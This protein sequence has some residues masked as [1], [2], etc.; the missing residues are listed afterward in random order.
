MTRCTNVFFVESPLQLKNYSTLKAN[1]LLKAEDD[2]VVVV[3]LNDNNACSSM[4]IKLLEEYNLYEHAVFFYASKGNKIMLFLSALKLVAN[5][6]F[7][8]R[9]TVNLYLGDFRSK[10]MG[11]IA[12]FF[13][14][15]NVNFIDDGMATLVFYNDLISG[16]RKIGK[17]CRIVTSFNINSNDIVPVINLKT[18]K[19]KACADSSSA[20]IIGMPLVEYSMITVS[21]Y[22]SYLTTVIEHAR[23]SGASNIMYI[24]HRNENAEV[25]NSK[26]ERLGL[27]VFTLEVPLEDWFEREENPPRNYY[28]LYSTAIVNLDATYLGL[29]CYC[30]KPAEFSFKIGHRDAVKVVYEYITQSSDIILIKQGF[31]I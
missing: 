13:R 30:Y 24:P 15:A 19:I 17:N 23:N 27:K 28:S 1:G 21:D 5:L 6:K 2:T 7:K 20:V 9:D 4:I 3:R 16:K 31:E 26:C 12:S 11:F 22:S 18:E 25:V 10:W 29:K 8:H 14:T